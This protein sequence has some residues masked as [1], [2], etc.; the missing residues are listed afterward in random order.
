[1]LA[2]P[3]YWAPGSL[4]VPGICWVG[5]GGGGGESARS[6]DVSKMFYTVHGSGGKD[7]GRNGLVHGGTPAHS[8]QT[9]P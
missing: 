5:G 9:L 3:L 1:M 7:E 6:D 4:G 2:A 8:V